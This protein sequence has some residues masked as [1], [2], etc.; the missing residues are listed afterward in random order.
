MIFINKIY[1]DLTLNC[2]FKIFILYILN[3]QIINKYLYDFKDY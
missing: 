2:I 1:S 3:L